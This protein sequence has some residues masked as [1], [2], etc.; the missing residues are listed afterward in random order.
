VRRQNIHQPSTIEWA[1][2][3]MMSGDGG[4]RSEQPAPQVT[5]SAGRIWS[6]P[7]PGSLRAAPP[8]APRPWEQAEA[9]RPPREANPANQTRTHSALKH[10]VAHGLPAVNKIL[11]LG[12]ASPWSCRAIMG[13]D[14][15]RTVSDGIGQLNVAFQALMQVPRL[16]DVDR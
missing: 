4:R 14:M 9:W 1:V 16:R 13:M 3:Q 12:A 5:A 10:I 2:M 15:R 7:V 6:C 8:G 11:F